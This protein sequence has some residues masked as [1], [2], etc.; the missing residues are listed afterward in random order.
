MPPRHIHRHGG[1]GLGTLRP[2]HPSL[3]VP[4]FGLHPG[5]SYLARGG[6]R[7]GRLDLSRVP[8]PHQHL[9]FGGGILL[10][11]PDADGFT[12]PASPCCRCGRRE[13]ARARI[14]HVDGPIPLRGGTFR[15]SLLTVSNGDR[16]V[17]RGL[18]HQ[19]KC[20]HL[21]HRTDFD[22]HEAQAT[23]TTCFQRSTRREATRPT[24][25]ARPLRRPRWL[26]DQ[27]ACPDSI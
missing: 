4:Q 12:L 25:R 22:Q 27:T 8:A 13:G 5:T 9:H 15:R 10:R 21:G 3:G 1:A 24:R 14:L 20:A 2:F 23:G 18:L 19:R 7:R 6:Q 17:S 11:R 16:S 26:E